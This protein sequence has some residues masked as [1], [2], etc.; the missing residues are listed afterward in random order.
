MLILGVFILLT[1]FYFPSFF[2]LGTPEYMA[3]E[4]ILR[5]GHAK[6]VD[7]WATGILIWE[8]ETGET[9]FA[10]KF[11]MDNYYLFDEWLLI[12]PTSSSL[13]FH[14]LRKL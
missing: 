10:G 4:I 7:Y 2:F 8:C 11:S 1:Y 5:K 6:G 9:P 14:R 12:T 13:F 3:P